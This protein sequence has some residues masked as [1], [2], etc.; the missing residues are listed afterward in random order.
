MYQWVAGS[1]QKSYNTTNL[2]KHLGQYHKD[3]Y[4]ELLEV[5]EREA[6][7]KRSREDKLQPKIDE[8]LDALNP[9][10]QCFVAITRTVAG[11]IATDF[12]PFFIVEDEGFRHL[13]RVL[14]RWYE[15]PSRKYFSER[16]IPPQMYSEL[17]E[18]VSIIL[19]PA[20]FLALTTDSWTSWAGDCYL[21]ITA[22]F[23]DDHYMRQLVVLDTFPLC[24]RHTAQNLL[25]NI[26]T[27]LESWEI[28]K[29]RITC[30]VRDNA[31]NIT[32]TVR[33]GGFAHIGCVDHLLQL[34]IN[35]GLKQETVTG[36]LKI[37]LCVV[38]HFHRSPAARQLL[39]IIQA[40]LQLPEHQLS[41]E[42]CTRWNSTFCM[43]ERLLE[44][45]RAVTTVL[46]DTT[47]SAELTIT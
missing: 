46:P 44:Q 8:T 15:L 14:D 13:L 11:M 3:T 47:C 43:L 39:K 16:V 4:K 30:F 33:E 26:L 34:A 35:D 19:K 27:I 31:A 42:V 29:K 17:R 10:S 23:I 41:Q 40:Q 45:H 37:A 5:E 24:E 32:A 18:K 7:R 36:L 22:H 38:G 21:S 6:S 20:V 1:K 12:Y 2:R 9:S 28:E 25:N